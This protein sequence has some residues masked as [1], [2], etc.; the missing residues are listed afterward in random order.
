MLITITN[1]KLIYQQNMIMKETTFETENCINKYNHNHQ[2]LCH[3]VFYFP[4]LFKTI[5]DS[6]GLKIVKIKQSSPKCVV[7]LRTIDFS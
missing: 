2:K 3:T 6:L 7:P 1:D 5:L 4:I